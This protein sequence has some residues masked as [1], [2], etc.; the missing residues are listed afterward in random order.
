MEGILRRKEGESE[1]QYVKRLTYGKLV[2]KTIDEDFTELSPLIFGQELSSTEARKRMYGIKRLL[3]LEN[4]KSETEDIT[5]LKH[6][7]ENHAQYKTYKEKI[8]INKDGTYTSDRLIGVENE[9]KLK[10]ENFLLEVHGYNKNRWEIVSARNSIWNTQLKGGKI[11]KLYASKI[12]VKPRK[13]YIDIDELVEHLKNFGKDYNKTMKNYKNPLVKDGLMFEIPICDLHLGK[14]AFDM[15]TYEKVDSEIL[16]KRFLNVISDFADRVKGKN[17]EKIIF[18]IGN[19]FF[20]SDTIDNTTTKGTRQDNDLRWQMLFL[21]GVE[22]LIKGIDIL[23]EIAPVDVFYIA[24]NHDKMSSY[25]A[26]VALHGW[27]RN[28]KRVFINLDP[29]SRKYVE[30]GKCLIGF[31]HGESEKT[32]IE[33]LMQKEAREAWGRTIHHEWHLGHLHTEM[34]K[35]KNAVLLRRIP[36]ITG[37]DAWHFE[38]GYVGNIKKAQAFLWHKDYGLIENLYSV[39]LN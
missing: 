27:Y 31:S 28:D 6:E 17:I 36:T 22:L 2:D 30:F 26:L 35:N 10:D 16:E 24:G 4:K 5:A 33:E 7:Y 18:P 8:D 20:N 3:E 32:R 25:H 15:E 39:I 12:N 13:E 38:S 29:K 11:T 34:V 9:D 23:S 37:T 14:L 1:L 21:K 19:D